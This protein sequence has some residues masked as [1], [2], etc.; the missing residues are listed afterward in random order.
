MRHGVNLVE[1]QMTD[2][3]ELVRGRYIVLAR[4]LGALFEV[5]KTSQIHASNRM[6]VGAGC[7]ARR[8]VVASWRQYGEADH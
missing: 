4:R 6:T 8:G 5:A 3:S 2:E 1:I 7:R